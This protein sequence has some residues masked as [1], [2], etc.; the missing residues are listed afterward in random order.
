MKS[1]GSNAPRHL[2]T[3]HR[4]R[5]GRPIADRNRPTSLPP[6]I[7]PSALATQTPLISTVDQA[8]MRGAWKRGNLRSGGVGPF[9]VEGA[10][11]NALHMGLASSRA[12]AFRCDSS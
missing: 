2:A 1:T 3:R 9:R 8:I 6:L 11:L 7:R 5:E 10:L 4:A 12:S